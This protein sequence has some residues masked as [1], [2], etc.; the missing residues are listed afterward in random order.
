MTE[1]SGK[2]Y[3]SKAC[4]DDESNGDEINRLLISNIV[5]DI[6]YNKYSDIK[7]IYHVVN[8]GDEMTR[9]KDI[10]DSNSISILRD[11]EAQSPMIYS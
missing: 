3:N 11:T 5:H 9:G 6:K 8:I 2:G 4:H 10:Q 7:E 1:L